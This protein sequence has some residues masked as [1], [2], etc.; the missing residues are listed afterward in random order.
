MKK[1]FKIVFEN[2]DYDFFIACENEE[3]LLAKIRK[4][5]KFDSFSVDGDLICITKLSDN[6]IEINDEKISS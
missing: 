6:F 3:E 4:W 5:Q 2:S 1:L